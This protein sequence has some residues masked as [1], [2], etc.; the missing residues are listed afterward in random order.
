M[1]SEVAIRVE[2]LR[3]GFGDFIVHENVSFEVA[4]GEVFAVLGG[5]GCGKTVLLKHRIGLYRPLAGKV[6]IFGADL[7]AAAGEARLAILKRF[8]VMYQL[9]ALF[10]NMTLAENI[11]LPLE[12]Y[13]DLPDEAMDLIAETKLRL[14]NLGGAG[15]RTPAEI[16]GGM[17]KR[18][19]IAR[20]MALDPDIIFLDEPSGGLDPVTSAELDQLILRLARSLGITF[21]VITHELPS[22]FAIA[23]RCIM[24]DKRVKGIIAEGRPAE[25]RDHSPD[26]RVRRFFNREPEPEPALA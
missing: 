25:L 13:T 23:D 3:T 5:S 19:A 11:R 2:A 8:G 20:A 7:T 12:E 24:L 18:A 22:I 21:V 26:P 16:S 4:R 6:S 10:G 9:G 17:M 14:V 1:S 15:Q